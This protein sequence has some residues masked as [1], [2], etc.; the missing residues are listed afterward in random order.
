MGNMLKGWKNEKFYGKEVW[1]NMMVIWG[2]HDQ[3]KNDGDVREECSIKR[4]WWGLNGQKKDEQ[5]YHNSP[6]INKFW[7]DELIR[8]NRKKSTF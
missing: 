2:K 5:L 7:H 3:K 8:A 6:K 4:G 1:V